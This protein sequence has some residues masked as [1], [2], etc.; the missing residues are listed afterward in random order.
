MGFKKYTAQI[1]LLIVGILLSSLLL[2]LCLFFFGWYFTAIF[3]L[4]ILVILSYGLIKLVKS[5]NI[6]LGKQVDS[7][8]NRDFGNRYSEKNQGLDFENL[9]SSLNRLTHFLQEQS[10][11]STIES[12][13]FETIINQLPLGVLILKKDKPFF[14]NQEACEFLNIKSPKDQLQLKER[15]PFFYESIE[16][17]KTKGHS[18]LKLNNKGEIQHWRLEYRH[19]SIAET[20]YEL[21]IF[22]N[23][24]ADSERTEEEVSNRLMHVLTHEIM[25]SISPVTSLADTLNEQLSRVEN[26]SEWENL[27]DIKTSAAIIKKRSEGLIEFVERY[28]LLAQLPRLKMNFVSVTEITQELEQLVLSEFEKKGIEFLAQS[29][30]T[31]LRFRADKQLLIQVILNL[32]KNAEEAFDKTK[33]AR[34]VLSFSSGD[35]YN[36]ISISDNAGGIPP[37][38]QENVFLPF[39]TTKDKASGI[40]L[41]L[42][43]KIIQAHNGRLYLRNLQKGSDFR[44][45]LPD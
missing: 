17:L 34:V 40:G 25:N 21:F 38:I 10:H 8:L 30:S 31:K 5:N 35:G 16:E 6:K 15:A 23:H 26:E 19:F 18:A 1:Y 37:E 22:K 32:I 14:L 36:Y 29:N 7:I 9:H 2:S 24:Q 33:E 3:T 20:A 43:R 13:L 27:E 41:S 45:E 4:V 44:I 11:Q 12:S 28:S 42:S 39:F